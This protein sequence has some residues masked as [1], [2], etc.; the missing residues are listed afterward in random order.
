MGN[1]LHLDLV[2]TNEE[3]KISPFSDLLT[4]L[5]HFDQFFGEID[6]N[7]KNALHTLITEREG[8]FI[9]IILTLQLGI[10]SLKHDVTPLLSIFIEQDITDLSS[11]FFRMSGL[12]DHD[13]RK[14][15][16]IIMGYL[17]LVAM[18]CNDNQI[19]EEEYE[20]LNIYIPTLLI[21]VR[22]AINMLKLLENYRREIYS[23]AAKEMLLSIGFSRVDVNHYRLFEPSGEY[24]DVFID[25]NFVITSPEML[26]TTTTLLINV[27]KLDATKVKVDFKVTDSGTYVEVW[28]DALDGTI[29]EEYSMGLYSALTEGFRNPCI[30]AGSTGG[31][32]IGAFLAGQRL[33]L[34]EPLANVERVT[35]YFEIKYSKDLPDEERKRREPIVEGVALPSKGFSVYFPD[36]INNETLV[37]LGINYY[38]T[39]LEHFLQIAQNT[40][41]F[42]EDLHDI[43]AFL[44]GATNNSV[45]FFKLLE[46]YDS[47]SFICKNTTIYAEYFKKRFLKLSDTDELSKRDLLEL[48]QLL[49][50][51]IKGLTSN[52]IP[53]QKLLEIG[54]EYNCNK[55]IEYA[56]LSKSESITPE[57]QTEIVGYIDTLV[58]NPNSNL[59][60]MVAMSTTETFA[61][62]NIDVLATKFNGTYTQFSSKG[63]MEWKDVQDLINFLELIA[64][65]Q[66][67]TESNQLLNSI[68]QIKQVLDE[69]EDAA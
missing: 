64:V 69:P 55:I 66:I 34:M 29:D 68:H 15:F 40:E 63:N 46:N 62:N 17:D 50:S 24:L 23:I 8:E 51:L 36:R 54:V 7:S 43:Y 42:S 14:S 61:R 60:A 19:Q 4:N 32:K 31:G 52:S 59:F 65:V 16:S 47:E 39:K 56:Q 33:A 5:Q 6:V 21:S 53:E 48:L 37:N 45:S 25:E 30:G 67:H 49:N 44:E 10:L 28:D 3:E 41:I 22:E 27:R 13:I 12:A 57:Q 20:F 11:K 26:F 9:S 2:K 1:H 18:S 38:A 35:E 58:N